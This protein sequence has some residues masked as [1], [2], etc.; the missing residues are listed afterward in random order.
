MSNFAVSALMKPALQRAISVNVSPVEEN[1][2]NLR[3]SSGINGNLKE[4]NEDQRHLHTALEKSL[5]NLRNFKEILRSL[6]E[7]SEI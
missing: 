5:E 6:K 4:F 3:K 1:P 7:F 2:V